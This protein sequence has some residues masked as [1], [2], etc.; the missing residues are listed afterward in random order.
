MIEENEEDFRFDKS[1]RKNFRK[2]KS[3]IIEEIP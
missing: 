1:K 3:C 2:P